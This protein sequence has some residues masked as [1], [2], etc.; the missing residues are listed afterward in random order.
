MNVQPI[1]TARLLLAGLVTGLVMNIGEA[2]L[3]AGILGDATTAAYNALNRTIVPDPLNLVS[4]I[5]VTFAQGIL[6]A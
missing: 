2:T 5:G 1:R 3:H 4:L 6:L